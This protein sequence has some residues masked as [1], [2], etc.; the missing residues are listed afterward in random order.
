[1][2]SLTCWQTWTVLQHERLSPHKFKTGLSNIA[3]SHLKLKILKWLEV[4][5]SF[6]IYKALKDRRKNRHTDEKL[7]QVG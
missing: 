6:N 7:A 3:K 2:V 5:F 1:M 4:L